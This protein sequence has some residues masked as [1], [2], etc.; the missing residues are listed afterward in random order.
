MTKIKEDDPPLALNAEHCHSCHARWIQDRNNTSANQGLEELPDEWYNEQCGQCH[1][2]IPV[3][4]I[5][6]SDWG[7]CSNVAS[8]FDGRVRFEHDGCSEYSGASAWVGGPIA[9]WEKEHHK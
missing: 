1:Y 2:Y 3:K 5:L 6:A 7:V 4:G 9:D 8:P